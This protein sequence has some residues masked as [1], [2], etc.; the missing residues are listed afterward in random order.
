MM[1]HGK[2]IL[3]AEDDPNDVMI[4]RMRFNRATL[5]HSLNVVED[6]QGAIDWLTGKG[7]FADREKFPIPNLLILDLKMP[8]KTGFDVLEW[9]RS[10]PEFE[11]LRV[12]I[13]SSLDD[14]GDVKRA[15][16][17]GATSYFV[18]SVSFEELLHYL[19]VSA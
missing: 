4:F 16:R 12:I 1:A 6:G 13:L 11:S 8:R 18:K 2:T 7:K 5:P 3:Y 10:K 14:P 9:V 19:R 15:Y 17:L